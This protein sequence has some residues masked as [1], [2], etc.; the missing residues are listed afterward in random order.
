MLD[1]YGKHSCD[2][3]YCKPQNFRIAQ[4]IGVFAIFISL[5][6]SG[7]PDIGE[8]TIENNERL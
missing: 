2:Y 1:K 3:M 4:C 7:S 5:E 8:N 6:P